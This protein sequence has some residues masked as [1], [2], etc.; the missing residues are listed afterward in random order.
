VTTATP[1]DVSGWNTQV[2]QIEN[3]LTS[4]LNSQIQGK[5]GGKT[6]AVDPGGNGKAIA[7][8]ISPKIPNPGDQ[9]AAANVTI[10]ATANAVVY[11]P[12]DVRNDVIA[13]LNA[14][15]TQGDELAPGKLN[16]QPCMVT[17]ASTD[18]TVILSCSASDFAQPIVNLAGLKGQLAGKN[19]GDAQKVIQSSVDKVQGVTVSEFPF[20]LFYLPFFSSRIEIDENFVA[21]APSTP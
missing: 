2:T 20:R 9:F 11:D 3:T 8:D 10:N 6:I 7:F 21:A 19:P 5:T 15:V 4:Q 17:Q 18:G 14:Q 12:T 13:D 16:L 1:T